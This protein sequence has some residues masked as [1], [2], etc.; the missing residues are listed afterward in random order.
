M[1]TIADALGGAS[2]P[3]ASTV[4]HWRHAPTWRVRVIRLVYPGLADALDR[5]ESCVREQWGA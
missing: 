3:F 1:T 2:R 4:A 5:L